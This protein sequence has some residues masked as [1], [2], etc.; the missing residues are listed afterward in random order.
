MCIDVRPVERATGWGEFAGQLGVDRIP[1]AILVDSHGKIAVT[2]EVTKV[3]AD[4]MGLVKPT[5]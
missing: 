3:L 4:A 1:F 2:G 5:N